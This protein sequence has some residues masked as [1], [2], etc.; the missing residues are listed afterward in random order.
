MLD[1]RYCDINIQIEN[2]ATDQDIN[3]F[4]LIKNRGYKYSNLWSAWINFTSG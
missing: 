1:F 3:I 4:F 2:Q